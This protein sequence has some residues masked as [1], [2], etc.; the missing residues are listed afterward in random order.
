MIK[1]LN[2]TLCIGGWVGARIVLDGYGKSRRH[3]DMVLGPPI[4]QRVVIPSELTRLTVRRP[5]GGINVEDLIVV[6]EKY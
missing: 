2:D 3:R 6:T 4:R 5:K 1:N